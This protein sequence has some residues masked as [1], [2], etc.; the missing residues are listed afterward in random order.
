VTFA[1]GDDVKFVRKGHRWDGMHF[2]IV[3]VYQTFVAGKNKLM[4][5]LEYGTRSLLASEEEVVEIPEI[6]DFGMFTGYFPEWGL[7]REMEK[8]EKKQETVSCTHTNKRE[9]YMPTSG[10][11]WHCPDCKKWWS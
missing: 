3:N 11:F 5:D 2:K 9:S 8:A 6:E 4:Y 1:I 10:K 7:S